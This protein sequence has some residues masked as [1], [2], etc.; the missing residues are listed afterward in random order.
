M[1]IRTNSYTQRNRNQKQKTWDEKKHGNQKLFTDF[2][3]S[4]STAHTLQSKKTIHVV[5]YYCSIEMLKLN[6]PNV[7]SAAAK[8]HGIHI[9][10]RQKTVKTKEEISK[11]NKKKR[12]HQIGWS[13]PMIYSLNSVEFLFFDGTLMWNGP[14]AVVVVKSWF[15]V[16]SL[17]CNSFWSP[18]SNTFAWFSDIFTTVKSWDQ[19]S[20][21]ERK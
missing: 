20:K 4:V 5:I 8:V 6:V 3:F 2:R 9:F 11:I 19:T 21:K 14:F 17:W 16:V 10:S 15:L 13:F 18:K 7:C 12:R 1:N